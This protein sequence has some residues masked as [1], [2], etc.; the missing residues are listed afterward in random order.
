MTGLVF[1]PISYKD[2]FLTE[3]PAQLL[4]RNDYMGEIQVTTS[5][6]V[7]NL[8]ESSCSSLVLTTNPT[9]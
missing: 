4:L 7:N 5:L 9:D 1:T 8:R 3:I 2:L 6:G